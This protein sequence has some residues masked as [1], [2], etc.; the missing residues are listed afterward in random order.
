MDVPKNLLGQQAESA[1]CQFLLQQGFQ[2]I[3]K[4]Y[5]S[6]Q[7]EIDLI[8][9]DKADLVFVEV[10]SRKHDH[11]GNALESITQRKQRNIIQTALMYLQ[12][13]KLL[14]RIHC[15]FDI[16]GITQHHVEWIKDAF[17]IK[18]F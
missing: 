1:A 12:Q 9:Q 18:F 6:K 15:R 8:M 2:F 4:N 3:A 7:G 5:R 13:K 17:P 10:R 16:I 11:F 14:D